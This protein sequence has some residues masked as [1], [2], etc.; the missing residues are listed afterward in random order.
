MRFSD[1]VLDAVR[2][3]VGPDFIVGIRMVA[4][5]QWDI[6]LSREEGVGI[7][8]RL[9]GSGKVDFLNIIRGHIDHDAHLTNVIPIQGMAASPH[10]DFAGGCPRGHEVSGFPRCPH[11]RCRHRAPC[12]RRG[13]ARYGRHDARSYWPI[14]TS[15]GRSSRAAKTR[16]APC[17]RCHPTVSTASMKAGGGAVYSQCGGQAGKQP[18][19]M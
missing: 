3:A 14:R 7:A 2:K 16:S 11:C 17:V 5:E 10:L 9:A 1:M 13:Q 18:S 8:K 19:R 15:S 6:G 12:D 4:D